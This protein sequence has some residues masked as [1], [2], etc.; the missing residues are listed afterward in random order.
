[1]MERG[2]RTSLV[3]S[4]PNRRPAHRTRRVGGRRGVA[5][6]PHGTPALYLPFTLP[7][8]TVIAHRCMPG[9]ARLDTPPPP[10]NQRQQATAGSARNCRHFWPMR[11]LRCCNMGVA[12]NNTEHGNPRSCRTRAAT[13]CLTPPDPIGFGVVACRANAAA[14]DLGVRRTTSRIILCLHEHRSAEVIDE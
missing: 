1:M 2:S 12:P 14:F 10:P 6:L 3:A 7:G 11:G 4:R 13:G 9:A 8:E 5:P